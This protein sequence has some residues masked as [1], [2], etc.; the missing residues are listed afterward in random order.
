MVAEPVYFLEG[1]WLNGR[2]AAVYCDKGYAQKWSEIGQKTNNDPQ[3][4]I[5][6]NFVVYALTQAGGIAREERDRYS[7]V[8]Q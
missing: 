3:L 2:L 7:E 4:R 8:Y 1:I 5:G 6:V